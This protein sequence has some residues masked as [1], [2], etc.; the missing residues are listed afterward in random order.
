MEQI[1]SDFTF[2]SIESQYEKALEYGYEIIT[3]SQYVELKANNNL[4]KLTIVNR[5]DI[6]LSL[7]K[8]DRRRLIFDKLKI[9]ATFF[10]RVHAKEYN[11]FSFEPGEIIF[12]PQMDTLMQSA[13]GPKTVPEKGEVVDSNGNEKKLIKP[14]NN[15]D[16]KRLDALRKK[17]KELVPSNVNKTGVKNI[18]TRDGLVVLGGSMSQSSE[19]NKSG[20][21]SRDRV[22][23]NL[24][25]NTKL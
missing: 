6:D 19:S 1:K 11:P 16:V 15:T 13:I 20:S 21:L 17:V 9:K 24:N 14:R 7:K 5:V 8:A 4:P 23:T 2:S 25:N 3:C 22:I 18:V 12:S 10:V